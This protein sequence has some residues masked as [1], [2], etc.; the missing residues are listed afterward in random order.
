[1]IE[2]G[3]LPARSEGALSA[4]DATDAIMSEMSKIAD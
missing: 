3:L 4:G 2:K 1:M